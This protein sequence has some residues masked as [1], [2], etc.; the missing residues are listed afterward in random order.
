MNTKRVVGYLFI[1]VAFFLTI[2]FIM[3]LGSVIKIFIGIV[4]TISGKIGAEAAGEVFGHLI[5]WSIHV[6]ITIMLWKYGTK[7]IKLRKQVK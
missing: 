3:Q 2:A 6:F 1:V 5:Y 7:W 4:L